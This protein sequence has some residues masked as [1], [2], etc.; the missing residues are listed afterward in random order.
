MDAE[1]TTSC[2][3]QISPLRSSEFDSQHRECFDPYVGDR[4]L[5]LHN[6][7]SDGKKSWG[8]LHNS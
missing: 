4:R 5:R 6:L 1:T 8:D 7:L 3:M 2:S